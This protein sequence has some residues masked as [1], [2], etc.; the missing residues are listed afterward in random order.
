MFLLLILEREEARREKKK[1]IN[2]KKTL[3]KNVY[4]LAQIQTNYPQGAQ[5]DAQ[6]IESHW[7]G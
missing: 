1:H 4:A 7:P 2:V 6:R 5:D 3:E